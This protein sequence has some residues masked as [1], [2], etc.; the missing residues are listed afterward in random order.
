MHTG[1][2][3]LGGL[4][5]G[6][7]WDRAVRPGLQHDLQ[8]GLCSHGCH[9]PLYLPTSSYRPDARLLR[10][11][12]LAPSHPSGSEGTQ[13]GRGLRELCQL[14][15]PVRAATSVGPDPLGTTPCPAVLERGD[16][17]GASGPR[18]DMHM[19]VP[20]VLPPISRLL[21]ACTFLPPLPAVPVFPSP[22]SLFSW[23]ARPARSAQPRVQKRKLG[24]GTIRVHRVVETE[25][26]NQSEQKRR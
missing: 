21:V 25:E 11:Y 19:L 3:G 10:A 26:R 23:E 6:K 24:L 20:G 15:P 17:R 13:A 22:A 1:T 16:S 18:S 8:T 2:S 9:A 7:L 5:L 14:A 12:R 4:G